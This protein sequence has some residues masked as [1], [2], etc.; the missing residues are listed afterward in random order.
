LRNHGGQWRLSNEP[1]ESNCIHLKYDQY[2]KAEY[3]YLQ[4]RLKEK[5]EKFLAEH[6]IIQWEM[7]DKK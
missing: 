6:D 1:N 2:E 4:K 7:E 5:F 3:Y